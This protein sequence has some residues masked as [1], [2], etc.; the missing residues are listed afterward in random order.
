ML[1]RMA[2]VIQLLASLILDY[3]PPYSGEELRYIRKCGHKSL[4]DLSRELAIPEEQLKKLE[5][6]VNTR[7]VIWLTWDRKEWSGSIEPV[8][9][10]H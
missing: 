8:G 10:G 6:T 3:G 2:D 4:Q 9:R 1:P 5:E 7:N